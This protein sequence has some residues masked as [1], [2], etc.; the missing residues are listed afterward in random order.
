GQRRLGRRTVRYHQ[1]LGREAPALRDAECCVERNRLLAF[2][3]QLP[4][5]DLDG[6]ELE[7][8]VGGDAPIGEGDAMIGEVELPQRDR[9]GRGGCRR[10][11]AS[12]SGDRGCW[13]SALA[14]IRRAQHRHEWDGPVSS[15]Y[16]R[17]RP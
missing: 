6:A 13:T 8:A 9:P 12:A 3:T 17:R 14:L 4:G 11:G 15:T 5:A 2:A 7:L 10:R 16:H 1:P